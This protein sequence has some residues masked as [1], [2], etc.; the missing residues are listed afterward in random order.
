LDQHSN[1]HF[2]GTTMFNY[3]LGLGRLPNWLTRSKLHPISDFSHVD[4]RMDVAA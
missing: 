3:A 1:T 4:F 2:D